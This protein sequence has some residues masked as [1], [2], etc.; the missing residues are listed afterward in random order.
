MNVEIGTEASQFQEKEYI[1]GILLEL[2]GGERKTEKCDG[3]KKVLEVTQ[4]DLE[5]NQDMIYNTKFSS[6]FFPCPYFHIF[7]P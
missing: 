7:V 6:T 1:N 3:L 4:G 5:E 2:A